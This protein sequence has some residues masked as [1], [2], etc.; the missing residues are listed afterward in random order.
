MDVPNVVQLRAAGTA[1]VVELTG[2]V[3]RVLHW[4]EDLGE[5]SDDGCAALLL[6]A[7]ASVLNNAPDVPRR[8]SVWPTEAEGWSGTPAHEGHVDGTATSPRPRLT[9][10][11]HRT[12]PGGGAELVVD[13]ADDVSGLDIVL[14]YRLD[15]SGVLAVDAAL[16]RTAGG[17]GRYQV[18]GVSTFLPLPGR[19]AE[20]LDFTGKW[21]R[22][23][24]PQRRPLDFGGYAREIRRGK[25]GPDSPYLLVAGVPGFRFR[26]GEV[27]GVHVAWSG[28]QRYLVER[29]PEGAGVHASALGGGELLR[30]GE[31]A[32][33]PGETYRTPVCYFAWS[34]GG[35]DGL[36]GRFHDLLRAR[37]QHPARPRPL[38]LNTWEAVYFD[39]DLERLL[40][41]A[42]RAAEVG[43]ERVVLDDG[44]FRGR[45]DDTAGLG[46]WFV[47]ENVWP[48]GLA[49]LADHVHGLGMEFGLWVEPEMVNLGSELARAHP[50]WVLGPASGL[51]LGFRHQYVLNI[52]AEEAWAYLLDR[53]DTL[54]GRYSIDYLKWDHNRDLLEAVFGDA[55]GANRPAVHAQTTALYRLL[56][57]LK[58]RHPALEIETCAAGGGRIDLGI[59][60]RTDRVWASDCNDPVERQAI[61]R[62]TGQLIPPELIG[63]HVGAE[64]AHTTGRLTSAS[65]RLATALFGHAGI[66][67]D[68]TRCSAEELGR[69]AAW[70][71][72][73]REFRPLL[74]QGRVVRADTEDEATLLHGVVSRD[75]TDALYCW[76]RTVTSAAGQSGRVR[77]PG[78]APDRDHVVRIRTDLGPPSMHHIAAP[79]W[80]DRAMRDWVPFPGAV[81]ARAGLPMPTLDPQQAMLIEVRPADPR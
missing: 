49:P 44:W 1:V 39:H 9:G 5:L 17:A 65:F 6:S 10:A 81:L 22:E 16:T 79:A 34:D 3:P 69:M 67:Q 51:G 25:P 33:G 62:W 35:L 42:D 2:T 24:A 40:A 48:N 23:R 55:G 28:N 50:D 45:R 58:T 29:P 15:A 8:F 46:D 53:L 76:A 77:L 47:D 71:A 18:A 32:L 7:E 68:L 56:D 66:E 57:T 27:W 61:Q 52:A 11:R 73:Y 12:L 60:A 80:A 13:L 75:G 78:L 38:T 19:A 72:M 64:Q 37:P 31:I 63:S 54:V 74:H 4:G 20:L 21:C 14:T 26:T 43:V 59:L 70:A 41:L 30:P 36:A